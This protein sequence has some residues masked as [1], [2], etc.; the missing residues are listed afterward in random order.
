MKKLFSWYGII[1]G[2]LDWSKLGQEEEE[3]TEEAGSTDKP[4]EKTAGKAAAP[5]KVKTSA[6]KPTGGVKAKTTT[7]RKM[8]S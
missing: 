8:G 3:S 2:L 6:P 5:K 1:K 4:A 7:P